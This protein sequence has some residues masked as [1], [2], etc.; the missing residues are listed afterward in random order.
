MKKGLDH[1]ANTIAAGFRAMKVEFRGHRV[2]L[3]Q[4]QSVIVSYDR[5]VQ[6]EQ[7]AQGQRI[8][9]LETEL[10][11]FKRKGMT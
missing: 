1:L 10:R 8:T 5:R 4:L 6:E 11:E 2:A 9:D 7:A 3:G